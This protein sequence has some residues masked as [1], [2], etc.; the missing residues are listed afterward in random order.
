MAFVRGIHR[1]PV[2]SPHKGPVTRKMSP[3]DDV[4]MYIKHR[5]P[6]RLWCWLQSLSVYLNVSVAEDFLFDY[7]TSF[8]MAVVQA[9]RFDMGNERNWTHVCSCRAPAL[10]PILPTPLIQPIVPYSNHHSTWVLQWIFPISV[11]VSTKFIHS[12]IHSTDRPTN[13]TLNHSFTHPLIHSPIHLSSIIHS[14]EVSTAKQKTI[15]NLNTCW[16][17]SIKI[18]RRYPFTQGLRGQTVALVTQRWYTGR[19]DLAMVASF[20]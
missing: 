1:W 13:Q 8:K 20:E 2:K 7:M 10:V 15:T 19:P 3:F 16:I 12:F 11:Q 9:V 4:I 14:F 18:C 5:V 6:R 17:T